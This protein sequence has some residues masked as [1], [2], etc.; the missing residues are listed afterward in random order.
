MRKTPKKRAFTIVELLVVMS[1]IMILISLLVPSLNAIKRYAKGVTQ[2]GQFHNIENALEMF[3][4]DHSQYPDSGYEDSDGELYCGAMKLCEALMGQDG[5]GFHPDSKFYA[6]G[7]DGTGAGAVDLYL[8]QNADMTDPANRA[9]LRERKKYLESTEDRM[10]LH[11]IDEYFAAGFANNCAVIADVFKSNTN[12]ING[13]KIGLPVLYYRADA[14][15]MEHDPNGLSAA[16][17]TAHSN[18]YDIYDNQDLVSL[19]ESE[20]PD[21]L[22]QIDNQLY[23]PDVFYKVTLDKKAN[24]IDG[25]NQPY[26]KDSY[27]LI[28]A[29]FDGL[30]GTRDDITNFKD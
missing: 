11:K 2:M 3:Q 23:N 10:E 9:N 18:I 7:K 24:T 25:F 20:T 17:W 15:N 22:T 5:L 27:I 1:I 16:S 8:P 28:S 29:G 6:S 13:E 30:Y 4:I 14:S 19:F 21:G 12:S 26:R